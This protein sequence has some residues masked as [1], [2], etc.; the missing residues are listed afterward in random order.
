MSVLYRL[1]CQNLPTFVFVQLGWLYLANIFVYYHD[2]DQLPVCGEKTK[3]EHGNK[4][5]LT[6]V[7]SNQFATLINFIMGIFAITAT[8]IIL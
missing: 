1:P 5:T 4:G 7:K 6:V 8:S 3:G 2:S